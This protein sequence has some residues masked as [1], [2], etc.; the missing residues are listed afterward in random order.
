MSKNVEQIFVANPVTT[1]N[2]NDLLYIGEAG[3][4]DAAINGANLKA[5]FAPG[6]G[7]DNAVFVTNT[8]GVA[9]TTASLLNGEL[10]IGSTGNEPVLGTLT[11]GTG[12]SISNAAGSITINA[13]GIGD[14]WVAIAGTTQAAAI[15]TNY[16]TQNSSLTT[17]TLPTTAPFGSVVSIQ[18]VGTG[19]WELAANTGQTII[20]G[21]S[22]TS[23]GGNISSTYQNDTVQVVAVV[24]NTTWLVNSAVT[25]EFIIV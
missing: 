12:I 16:V 15:N 20:F 10:V 8:T 23:S 5:L 2:N 14:T 9:T 6:T 19:G 13:T 25:N 4:T 24:A 17:I 21:R 3:T 1:I 18:G 11:A 7:N 22:V